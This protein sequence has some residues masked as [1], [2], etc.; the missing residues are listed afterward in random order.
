VA[1]VIRKVDLKVG[2]LIEIDGKKYEVVPAANGDGIDLE[3]PITPMAELDRLWGTR[4][5]SKKEFDRLNADLPNDGE[6]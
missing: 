4:P 1:T 6:G 5:G 3:P 2:E